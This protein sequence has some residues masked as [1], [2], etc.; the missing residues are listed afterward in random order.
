MY[1]IDY[2]RT[3]LNRTLELTNLMNE[4]YEEEDDYLETWLVEGIPDGSLIEEIVGILDENEQNFNY[5]YHLAIR[6]LKARHNEGF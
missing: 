1:D 2:T 3:L 6:L 4:L 5:Y